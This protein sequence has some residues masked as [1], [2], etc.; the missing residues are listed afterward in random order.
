MYKRQDNKVK[1]EWIADGY[2]DFLKQLNQWYT[3]GIIHKECF[4]M[5]ADT[6]RSYISKGAVGATCAWYSRIKMCIRD[7]FWALLF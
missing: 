1:P 6:I 3:D 5:D 7:S 4:T 2:V